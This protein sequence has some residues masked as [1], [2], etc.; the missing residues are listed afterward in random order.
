MRRFI[1]FCMAVLMLVL[2]L[3]LAWAFSVSAVGCIIQQQ[4]TV[5]II[6]SYGN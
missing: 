3:A 4:N 5:A 1:N 6:D 2:V